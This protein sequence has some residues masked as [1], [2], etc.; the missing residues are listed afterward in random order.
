MAKRHH[1]QCQDAHHE[2]N[3]RQR[4]AQIPRKQ[5]P[6][7]GRADKIR[8]PEA[9]QD[10][11]DG[12]YAGLSNGFEERTQIGEEGKMSAENQHRRQ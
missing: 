3:Q 10:Q 5:H 9:K 4:Q 7:N 6:G 1:H 8:Q 11:G 12:L 2:R